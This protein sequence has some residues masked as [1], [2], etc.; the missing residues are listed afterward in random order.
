MITSL[1]SKAIEDLNTRTFSVLDGFLGQE[2]ASAL[3]GEIQR[4]NDS[5]TLSPGE[6]AAEEGFWKTRYDATKRNDLVKWIYTEDQMKDLP[7]T[8]QYCEAIKEFVGVLKPHIESLA[9]VPS[10]ENTTIMLA[11]YPGGGSRFIRHIDNPNRNGRVLTCVYY[12]NENWTPEHG[13]TL[14]LYPMSSKEEYD[15]EPLCDR[16]VLFYS[17]ERNPH[18]VLP[19]TS[20]RYAAT[21]WFS[22]LSDE[23][24]LAALRGA[25]Q[26]WK[27]S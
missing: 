18:E 11:L 5:G 10:L 26:A 17:D 9:K 7:S 24:R 20:H 19:A 6:L 27:K 12:L 1:H 15:V 4:L 23:D 16:L 3:R 22:Y 25:F 21:L 14:R 8:R 13:G 2:F